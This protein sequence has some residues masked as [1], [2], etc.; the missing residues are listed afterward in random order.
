MNE[1]LYDVL[2]QYEPEVTVACVEWQEE[3][4]RKITEAEYGKIVEAFVRVMMELNRRG[5]LNTDDVFDPKPAIE[6]A[7]HYVL[8]VGFKPNNVGGDQNGNDR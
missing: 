1:S 3:H 5:E 4:G 7:V 6:T 2:Q 8:D